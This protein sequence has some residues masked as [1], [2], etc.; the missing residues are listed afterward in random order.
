MEAKSRVAIEAVTPQIDGGRFPVK[1]TAGETVVVECDAFADGHDLLAGVLRYRWEGDPASAGWS[2]APLQALDNDRWR[3]TFVAAQTGRYRYTVE[4]WIDH[5]ATWARDLAKRVDAGQDVGVD[6]RIGAELVRAAVFGA[7]GPDA[8]QLSAWADHLD[9][10]NGDAVRI[11]LSAELAA[12]MRGY[13]PREGAARYAPEL[14]VVVDRAR[15]RFGAWYEMFPR[16]TSLEPGRHATFRDCEAR[17]PYVASMGFDILYLP[18]IHPIGRDHRKGRNNAEAAGAGDPGSPWAI[19]AAEGG[20]TAIH[21]ELGTF[22]DFRRLII[23]ARGCGL[24]IALDLAYQ[25]APDHPYVREHPE[26]FRRRP[27]ATIQYAENPPKKYQDIYPFDF[28]SS[29]W[30]GLWNELLG[31]VR[32]W[33]GEGVRIFRVDNPHTKP[34]PFWEWLIDEIHGT[35]P[36]VIF[37]AEAF[38]RPKVMYR[39]AKLGFTQSYTYFTWRNTKAELIEYFTDLTRPPVSE[40]FRPNLWPNT[41]DILHKYLQDGG[42]PAFAVRLVLAATLGANYGIY[43][44]AYELIEHQS[45]APGSPPPA[46]EEYLNAEKYE[47]KHWDVGRP[48][49]LRGLI[50]SVN[51]VRREYTALQ[52]DDTLVFHGIDNDQLICYSKTSP[53]GGPPVL[54]VVNLDPHVAQAGWT[55]LSLPALGLGPDEPFAVTDLLSGTRYTWRGG[56]N[57]VSLH[58]AEQP[59]H[60]F[61]VERSP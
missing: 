46:S 17:L 3:G 32:F 19:G 59:G 8:E 16:S 25:C 37:L 61:R 60:I 40:F 31:V 52:R 39:L 44:P 51:A 33:I 54:V 47:I 57:Y 27:D 42:R 45:A 10:G 43:G 5:F 41:P 15:A 29:D 30:R 11:A 1:R 28:D 20:H 2:E 6:L 53:D 12:A 48:E 22:E 56:R 49:S 35:D 50:A 7:R 14:P 58:P 23:R 24:E 38:T 13:P 55:A 34:F 36:D 26:W 9:A 18:P 21:P 4:V